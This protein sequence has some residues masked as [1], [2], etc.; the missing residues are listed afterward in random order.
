MFGTEKLEW[1][2]YPMVKKLWRHVYLFRQNTQ[3]DR[4]TD[5]Q[6]CLCIA[7]HSKNWSI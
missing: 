2:G 4:R 6:P 5:R 3:R 7:S 1:R